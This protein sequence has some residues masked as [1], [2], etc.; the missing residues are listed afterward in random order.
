[1]MKHGQARFEIRTVAVG[2]GAALL[3]LLLLGVRPA[4]AADDPHAANAHAEA[5]REHAASSA[6]DPDDPHGHHSGDASHSAQSGGH[7]D[8][9]YSIWSD[10]PLWS[11]VAFVGFVLAI[12]GLG[13][14]DYMLTNMSAREQAEVAAIRAS[15]SDLADA[16]S[17]LNACRGRI[18]SLDE[19]IREV[20][21]EADRDA[22]TTRSDILGVADREAKLLGERARNEIRR[23]QDQSLDLLFAT[24]A[25]KVVAVTESRLRAEFNDDDQARLI[26]ETLSQLSS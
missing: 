17:R 2:A 22:A 16:K 10:L 24:L 15:E 1:M 11:A 8:E 14:W 21:S 20:L 5:G 13:L 18:E 3:V 25:E 26:G 4:L 19:T 9:Q 7:H 23:V 12:R 6:A